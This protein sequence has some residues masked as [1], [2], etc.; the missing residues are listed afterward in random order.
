[1]PCRSTTRNRSQ[2]P[3][4]DRETHMQ[5]IRRLIGLRRSRAF[6]LAVCASL[7]ISCSS[8]DVGK[9]WKNDSQTPASMGKVL[10]VAVAKQTPI[11]RQIE[12]EFGAR[13]REHGH[14]AEASDARL[15]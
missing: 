6:A 5:C 3:Y 1:R 14:E 11:R 9:V 15:P 8:T 2:C 7:A 10:V 12:D 4:T 13:L